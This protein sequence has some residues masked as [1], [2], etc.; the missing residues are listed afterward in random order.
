MGKRVPPQWVLDHWLVEDFCFS[1]D[2]ERWQYAGQ[3]ERLP[4][5]WY[6]HHCGRHA[7]APIDFF[8][9]SRNQQDPHAVGVCEMCDTVYWLEL[10]LKI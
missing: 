2:I 10:K 5:N 9:I 4:K 7:H 1:K 8:G 3:Y 6:C